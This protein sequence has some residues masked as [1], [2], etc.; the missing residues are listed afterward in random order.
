MSEQAVYRFR[1]RHGFSDG[2]DYI[3]HDGKKSVL[4]MK[5]GTR[6]PRSNAKRKAG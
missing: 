1:H 6:W 2:T 3:E 4:V 5:D